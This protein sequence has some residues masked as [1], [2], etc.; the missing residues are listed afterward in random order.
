VSRHAVKRNLR[1]EI[2]T[3]L[4]GGTPP[5]TPLTFY[6]LLIPPGVDF[7]SLQK[8]GLAI[9]ARR[10]V[11]HRE[12]DE[13]TVKQIDEQGMRWT[14]YET[15]IGT[16]SEV[17]KQGAYDAFC[18]VEHLI[19][20]RDDYRIAE[21]IV[22]HTHYLP[23]YPDFLK[24]QANI[25]EA[26]IVI[27]HTCY[28]PLIDLQIRWIGQERFC[29]ELVDN[30]DALM[31]LYSCLR[32]KHRKMYE[33]VAAS[34]AEYVLYGGNIVPEMIG[35]ER[36]RDY[37]LPCWQEFSDKLMNE[38]K[39]LGVHLDAENRLI[40]EI[41]G[42]STLYFIEALTPPPDCSISVAEARETWPDKKIWINFPSSIHVSSEKRIRQVTQEIMEQAGQRDG[43]LMGVTEDIPAQH[44]IRSLSVI[45]ETIGECC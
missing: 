2:E 14:H 24:Q 21:F 40:M 39:K 26:G 7:G 18:P 5:V 37:V 4:E 1:A 31:N 12:F 38:N 10:D 45:L 15:P 36:I 8:K 33:V 30:E 6:D 44:M 19:K 41:V 42:D 20:N 35:P 16:L 9:A 22:N 13:V 17:H 27:A 32:S 28:S 3:A 25:G 29:Y 34:P 11:F 23:R 43:F